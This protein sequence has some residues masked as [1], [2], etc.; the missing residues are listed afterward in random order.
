MNCVNHENR[1]AVYFCQKRKRWFCT[2]CG[3]HCEL[4]EK[5]CK[6]RL[7]C[8]IWIQ[9]HERKREAKPQSALPGPKDDGRTS[10]TEPNPCV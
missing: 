2:E 1:E 4:P 5:H 8:V 7:D 9:E 10:K 6:F 3:S